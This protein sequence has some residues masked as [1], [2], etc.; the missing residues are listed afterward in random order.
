M[1]YNP[2]G[3]QDCGDRDGGGAD[4]PSGY[5]GDMGEPILHFNDQP[6]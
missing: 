5:L 4:R 3:F 6:S 1:A 2:V